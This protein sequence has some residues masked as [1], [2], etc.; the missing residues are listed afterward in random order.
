MSRDRR[1]VTQ[2]G[3]N[4][5]NPINSTFDTPSNALVMM[6]YQLEYDKGQGPR[7][8]SSDFCK[9]S[10]LCDGFKYCRLWLAHAHCAS[11]CALRSVA[12][13][14]LTHHQDKISWVSLPPR[15][16][17]LPASR[18]PKPRGKPSLSSL[19][20]DL[21]ITKCKRWKYFEYISSKNL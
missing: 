15:N 21:G 12:A 5:S 7:R 2:P 1:D 13:P 8:A 4:F 18:C 20:P 9:C 3:G 6:I 16:P 17:Y 11:P 10:S 19:R 14:N